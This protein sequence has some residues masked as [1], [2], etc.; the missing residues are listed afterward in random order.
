MYTRSS[1]FPRCQPFLLLSF[2]FFPFFLHVC[3]L[4]ICN[5]CIF[6]LELSLRPTFETILLVKFKFFNFF[7]TLRNTLAQKKSPL[8]LIPSSITVHQIFITSRVINERE[9]DRAREK[10]RRKG[11]KRGVIK[12]ESIDRTIISERINKT[13]NGKCGNLILSRKKKKE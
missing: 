11:T 7:Q 10:E 12:E 3:T 13:G 8:R 4:I 1:K 6:R 2:F 5:S 9:S